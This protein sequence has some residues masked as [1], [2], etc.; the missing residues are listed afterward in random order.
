MSHDIDALWKRKSV[1][2]DNEHKQHV[3]EMLLETPNGLLTL[4]KKLAR[5][6]TN[7]RQF[8]LLTI[9]LRLEYI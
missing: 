7:S 4:V 9:V 6:A 1:Q 2:I 8:S 3:A 5:L